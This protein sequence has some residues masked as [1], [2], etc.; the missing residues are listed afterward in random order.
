MERE[1]GSEEIEGIELEGGIAIKHA[2]GFA[3]RWHDEEVRDVGREDY[4]LALGLDELVGG[5]PAPEDA[6]VLDAEE[7]RRGGE[8]GVQA[9]VRREGPCLEDGLVVEREL[10][11][12]A[13]WGGE[14]QVVLGRRRG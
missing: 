10:G 1:R 2:Y 3:K 5:R 9:E 4:F 11:E 12:G 8:D 14:Q 13:T 6:A 7:E